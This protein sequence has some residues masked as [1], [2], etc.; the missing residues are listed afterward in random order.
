MC[1]PLPLSILRAKETQSHRGEG[2]GSGR[3]AQR[4]WSPGLWAGHLWARWKPPWPSP[5]RRLSKAQ[6]GQA[7]PAGLTVSTVSLSWVSTPGGLFPLPLPA[8]LLPTMWLPGSRASG[9]RAPFTAPSP[10]L[11]ALPGGGP[12]PL[13][14]HRHHREGGGP[15]LPVG[16][17]QTS[18]LLFL[19]AAAP[20]GGKAG[21]S[22]SCSKEASAGGGPWPGAPGMYRISGEGRSQRRG[23]QGRG[24]V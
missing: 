21:G 17:G 14:T 5:S 8:L 7:L 15:W 1:L 19:V 11:F 16:T 12:H 6:P 22:W 23:S 18:A 24:Q 20:W 4:P 10:V 3:Q 2:A 9:R 13:S